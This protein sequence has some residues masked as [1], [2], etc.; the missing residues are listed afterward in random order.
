[1][2]EEYTTG[3]L[4]SVN[5]GT[6]EEELCAGTSPVLTIYQRHLEGTGEIKGNSRREACR[7]SQEGSRRKGGSQ[8]HDRRAVRHE[9]LIPEDSV[10]TFSPRRVTIRPNRSS[11]GDFERPGRT[12]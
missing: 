7:T 8:T 12:P 3:A 2:L 1:M 4:L 10:G 9:V 6:R 5:R 11:C